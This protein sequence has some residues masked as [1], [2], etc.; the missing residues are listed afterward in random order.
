MSSLPPS[1][2]HR[3][4][5]ASALALMLGASC[6]KPRKV[7]IGPKKQSEKA[8][9]ESTTH[10]ATPPAEVPRPTADA[11]GTDGAR[12]SSEP[13][14]ADAVTET[15]VAQSPDVSRKTKEADQFSERLKKLKFKARRDVVWCRTTVSNIPSYAR[16]LEKFEAEFAQW[17]MYRKMPVE[18]GLEAFEKELREML[19]HQNLQVNLLNI[20]P[21][22]VNTRELPGIIHGDRAW[23]F[24]DND[25]R[26]ISA[27]T[28]KVAGGDEAA[29]QRLRAIFRE[30]DRLVL[31]RRAK[32]TQ[33]AEWL[34]NLEI[35]HFLDIEYPIHVIE[36][37][38]LEKEMR[39]SGINVSVEEAL[40]RD[41]IGYLQNASLSY[42]EFNSSQEKLN[43][44]MQLLSR[45]KFL[46]ARST[47]FRKKMEEAGIAPLTGK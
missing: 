15:S 35:Y 39:Q 8:A 33:T 9:A 23:S 41:T 11:K 28:L 16:A 46:E 18:P 4:A 20:E 13:L 34:F 25:I 19:G 26:G 27:V 44:A 43:E 47:F 10:K 21:V 7:E 29:M 30:M 37:K 38:D 24:G 32:P 17:Q 36:E 31:V 12:P 14:G 22:K 2:L 6:S 5:L 1:L 45:S 3:A 42:K 40:R